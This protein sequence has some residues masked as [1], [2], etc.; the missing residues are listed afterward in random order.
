MSECPSEQC[1]EAASES[2]S[3]AEHSVDMELT[4]F[5]EKEGEGLLVPWPVRMSVVSSEVLR[6]LVQRN[7]KK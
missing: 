2:C 4:L 3:D 6:S 1:S 7:N 5:Q